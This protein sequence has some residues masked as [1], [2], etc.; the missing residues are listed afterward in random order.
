MLALM[1]PLLAACGGAVSTAPSG[2]TIGAHPPQAPV[3]SVGAAQPAATAAPRRRS[4]NGWYC[5]RACRCGRAYGGVGGAPTSLPVPGVP[6][7]T[8]AP[9]LPT[10]QYSPLRGRSR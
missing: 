2:G 8:P 4:A 5:R 7:P 3:S 10:Q 6:Q 1:L 9:E